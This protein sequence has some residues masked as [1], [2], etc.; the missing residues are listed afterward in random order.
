[1]HSKGGGRRI[2]GTENV[3][4]VIVRLL[5]DETSEEVSVPEDATGKWLFE[6]VCCRQGVMEER[7]YFGLRYLEHQILTPPTKQWIDLTRRVLSQLKNTKPLVVS[8]RVKHYP[9][10]PMGDIRLPKTC[11]PQH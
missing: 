10:D 2:G 9:P 11:N 6:E 4:S 8:F 5:E 7:E 3:F 1:M